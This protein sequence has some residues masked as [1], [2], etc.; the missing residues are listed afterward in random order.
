[1]K[2]DLVA[3]MVTVRPELEAVAAFSTP[4]RTN[5]S[6][7]VVTGPGAPPIATVDDLAGQEVFVRKASVYYESLTKL[8]ER[9]TAGGKPAVVI[10]EAPDVLEDD[11]ILEMV[12]AGLA[13]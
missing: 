3:A 12:N 7:V 8:N 5:V 13:P 11:D 4:T 2:V 9:L 1:G 10:N 6:E